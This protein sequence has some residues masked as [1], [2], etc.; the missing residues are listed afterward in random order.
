MPPGTARERRTSAAASELLPA[1]DDERYQED[2]HDHDEDEPARKPVEQARGTHA[3]P[4]VEPAHLALHGRACKKGVVAVMTAPDAS[5]HAGRQA[6]AA[7]RPAQPL[8]L[9]STAS[10]AG[11]VFCH[12]GTLQVAAS[13]LLRLDGLEERLEV[14]DAEAPRAVALDDLEEEG[15][16]ILHGTGED[17]EQVALLVAIGLDAELL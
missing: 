3:I 1:P 10:H 12:M 5:C 14:A 2:D 11:T 9:S 8:Q 6:G 15:R 4:V 7:E 16:P 17:L 13:G